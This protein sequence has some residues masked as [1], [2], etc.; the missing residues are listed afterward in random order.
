MVGV[1]IEEPFS[2]LALQAICNSA[3]KNVAKV[4][5]VHK[6]LRKRRVQRALDDEK[7]AEHERCHEHGAWQEVGR[8]ERS[9]SLREGT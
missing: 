7:Q 2:I 6:D 4:T 3:E 8:N 5:Q 9:I 1:L